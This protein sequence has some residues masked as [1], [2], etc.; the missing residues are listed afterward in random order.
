MP[1]LRQCMLHALLTCVALVCVVATRAASVDVV[2]D[3]DLPAGDATITLKQFSRISGVQILYPANAVDGVRTNRVSGRFSAREALRRMVEGSALAIVEDAPSGALAVHRRN[4]AG[5]ARP[6]PPTNTSVSRMAVDLS[7]ASAWSLEPIR[8]NPFEVRAD[9][10]SSYSALD[11]NAIT[12]FRID[13]TK[14]PATTSMFTQTF[15]DDVAATSIQDVIVDYSG[16]VGADPNN[17]GAILAMPGDRDGS[18]GGLGIRGLSSGPPKRDGFLG[19][20][21][22]FRSPTGYTDNF[23]TERIEVIE[24]PQSL[25]Y[26]AVGGGGVVNI[27]SKR[28]Q[29][30]TQKG[31]L[32]SRIDQYGSKRALFDENLGTNRVAVRVAGAFE[33]RNNVRYNLGSEFYG[34]YAS[35]AVRFG[36]ATVLRIYGERDSNSANVAFTPSA[37]DL[38][39]FLPPA[40][41]RRGLD[42]RYLALTHQLDDFNGVLWNGP[43][44]YEHISSLAGWWSSERIDSKIGGATLE[45]RLGRGFSVQL[46][47]VYS[48]TIDDR[49]TTSKNLVPAAGV[50]GSGANPYTVPAIRLT[51]GDNWQSDRTKG[52]RATLV[53][54]AEI[55]LGRWHGHSQTAIGIEGSH[56]GPAFASSGIDRLYYQADQ[57]WN[58]MT[59]PTVTTDY[60]RIP[61]G[62]L[63]IPLQSS[64]PTRPLFAPGTRRITLNGQNYV[65]EPRIRQDPVRVTEQNPFGL[66]PNNPTAT[67]PNGFN[68]AWNR[69][70]ETHDRQWYVA[71]FTDWNDGRLT[72]MAGVSVDRFTTLNAGPGT[73]VTYLA[74]RNYPGYEFGASYGLERIR[75]LRVYAAYSTAGLAAGTTKDFYGNALKVPRATSIWPEIGLKYNDA[76]GR[77]AAQLAFNPETKVTNE[78]RNPGTDYFN[79]VNPNGIN[80]RYNLGD[81]WINLDRK[82]ESLELVVTANPTNNWRMRLTATQLGGEVTN[83]VTYG[84]LYNDQ[85]Y[86]NGGFVTYRDGAPVMVDPA[87]TGGDKTTPLTLQMI[88]DPTNAYY[89]SPDPDSGRITRAALIAA[90]TTVDPVHGAAA[91]GVTGLPISAIQYAFSNPHQG[92]ITVVSAGDKTTGINEF[93]FNMQ[94]RYTFSS[95]RLRG[96]GLFF[97]FRTY[98]RD[99]A[100]YTMYFPNGKTGTTFQ[101]VR[102]LYRLPTSTVAG[103][104]ITYRHSLTRHIAWTTQLNIENLFDNSRVWVV[105]SSTNGSILQARLSNQPRQYIWTNSI[106]W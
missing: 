98:L 2:A 70:A 12:T 35:G 48:E 18:G 8:L 31:L 26:G 82:A 16:V 55:P 10:S 37:A 34:L 21:V 4:Q 47:L 68:G 59:S 91:T 17:V 95:G 62:S 13:L 75:G 72:T 41:P 88:N 52:V 6:A 99:R 42:P 22:V 100:F 61:L 69:G 24:G 56:Q 83:T 101:A 71:N 3:Y 63:Y 102:T 53:H 65:L 93:S 51:P 27:V 67:N 43:A 36:P 77:W 64:I 103:L 32:Q 74:P 49:F 28:P 50:S 85:F 7:P 76:E 1:R 97:D 39:N 106:S 80:G 81:Q 23:S 33:D 87:A 79:A 19:P 78:T 104:G 94:N 46:G 45:S 60:G 9:P 20:R 84:Q 96:L 44:D 58:P 105:P 25:L 40:D 92:Q 38:G 30:G 86:T 57:N 5:S 66:V 54:E 14:L 11:S 90:L 15:M 73:G 89:A 29:F